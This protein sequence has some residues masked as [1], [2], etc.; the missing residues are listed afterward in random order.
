MPAQDVF[1]TLPPELRSYALVGHYLSSFAI[2]EAQLN[3]TIAS[4]LK[5]DLLQKVIV[6]KNIQF[7]D[8]QKIIRTLLSVAYM[9]KEEAD[10]YDKQLVRLGE[11]SLDRNMVAHDLFVSD[12]NG[13]GIEFIVMKATGKLTFPEVRWSV[14]DVEAKSD[15]LLAL[16]ETLKELEIK[17]KNADLLKALLQPQPQGGLGLGGALLQPATGV[18]P[19]L[20]PWWQGQLAQA[21]PQLPSDPSSDLQETIDAKAP[22][23]PQE[24]QE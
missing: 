3:T 11:L 16:R 20:A 17:L 8:K 14:D 21:A 19:I 23:T 5:L 7:R 22:E 15:E 1:R 24:P 12:E 10:Q 2:M 13:D 18:A 6:T 4:A 9:P